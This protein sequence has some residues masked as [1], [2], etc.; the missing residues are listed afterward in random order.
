ML[1]PLAGNLPLLSGPRWPVRSLGAGLMLSL[2]AL[3]QS[4]TPLVLNVELVGTGLVLTWE[5]VAA[6]ES[7]DQLGATWS[8]IPGA[9][10]PRH[11]SPWDRQQF[12]R[13]GEPNGNTETDT[14]DYGY[15]PTASEEMPL[16][17]PPMASAPP[18]AATVNLSFLPPVGRQGTTSNPGS[19]GSC[20]AWASTYGLATFTAA[21]RGAYSPT[22]ATQWAS[23]ASIYVTVLQQDGFASN[24]CSGSQMTSYFKLL[25]SG[26]TPSLEAAP[27]T[28]SCTN[29]W[30]DYG[31]RVL[32]PDPTFTV[33]GIH[34]IATTN[35]TGLKQILASN[36]VL[37]Y[38][39]RLYTQWSAYR[40]DPVPYV[41]TGIIAKQANGKPV[42][43]C[44]LIIGYDD[45][46][47]AV[48]IQNSE[49]S[50]WGSTVDGN[51]PNAAGTD[52]GY[53]W[54]AYTT[55]TN[56]AQGTAFYQKEP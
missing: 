6:L 51:P 55:F 31:G 48:L 29:L 10:S 20:A 18:L 11:I 4:T 52:A 42:G 2:S 53:V 37:A 41:G 22:N 34:A 39:T 26:G 47:Q 15:D 12:F 14:P 21:K 27:Y 38:G 33:T 13:L 3:A 44:M 1:Y 46:K 50:G 43:H 45:T 17:D 30:S 8:P 9:A 40:G 35:L 5:G 36:R 19:P 16:T 54:M 32:P 28:P 49:G 56:L 23:P 7:S 25:A 24:S